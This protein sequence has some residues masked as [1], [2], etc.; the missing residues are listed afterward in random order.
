MFGVQGLKGKGK[1]CNR[2][3]LSKSIL[4]VLGGDVFQKV[5]ALQE[6]GASLVQEYCQ[7]LLRDMGSAFLAT[8][9]KDYADAGPLNPEMCV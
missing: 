2:E 7:W 3:V 5:V 8:M 9:R 4:A 1:G 6:S